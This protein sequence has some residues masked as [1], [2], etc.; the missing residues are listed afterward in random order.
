[1]RPGGFY[2]DTLRKADFWDPTLTVYYS[3]RKEIVLCILLFNSHTDS[4][5]A[6][7]E[8]FLDDLQDQNGSAVFSHHY[9]AI[10]LSRVLLNHYLKEFIQLEAQATAVG[11]ALGL[12]SNGRSETEVLSLN[13]FDQV[14]EIYSLNNDFTPLRFFVERQ[15]H[16]LHGMKIE[17]EKP[18]DSNNAYF[19]RRGNQ[20]QNLC[21][22]RKL[23]KLQEFQWLLELQEER[24]K[25]N[26]WLDGSYEQAYEDTLTSIH[27]LQADNDELLKA[28]G[29]LQARVGFLGQAVCTLKM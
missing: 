25:R 19:N 1:M 17:A 7:S 26:R 15:Q 21:E 4:G 6:I 9:T 2:C 10:V 29:F 18:R 22:G 8:S 3:P 12:E 24:H 16:T 27:Q 14:K 11:A 13:H 28:L 23:S 20:R 5:R